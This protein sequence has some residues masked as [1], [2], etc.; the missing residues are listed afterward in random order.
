MVGLQNQSMPVEYVNAE[1]L[2][3]PKGDDL[4]ITDDKITEGTCSTE[5]GEPVPQ[6]LGDVRSHFAY[7][8]RLGLTDSAKMPGVECEFQNASVPNLT[9][10]TVTYKSA[11]AHGELIRAESMT[12]LTL[13]DRV[14]MDEPS[15]EP[16]SLTIDSTVGC[17]IL[18][19]KRSYR[20]PASQQT[21]K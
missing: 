11:S 3:A 12:F 9:T 21:A 10:C 2:D 6:Q 1:A 4:R 20:Q 8:S 16:P 5:I 18:P 13:C 7:G 15:D 19:T 17:I 14:G